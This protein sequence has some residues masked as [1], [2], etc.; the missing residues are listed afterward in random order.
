MIDV[1]DDH[2]IELFNYY[3]DKHCLDIRLGHYDD[4]DHSA[5]QETWRYPKEFDE[6]NLEEFFT[7]ACNTPEEQARCLWEVQLYKEYGVERLLRWSIW[8][9]SFVEK[10]NLFV[11]VGRGSSVASY[12]LYKI[13]LHMV[14]SMECN[15]DPREFLK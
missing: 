9:M 12:C 8:F 15:L 2:E 10:N 3:A 7:L 6:I 13:G 5:R 4:I 1:E 11:G 14:N